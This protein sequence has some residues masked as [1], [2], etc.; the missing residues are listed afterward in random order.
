MKF[1]FFLLSLLC[2]TQI[3]SAHQING[4]IKDVNNNPIRYANVILVNKLDSSFVC[5]TISQQDGTYQLVIPKQGKYMFKVTCIGYYTQCVTYN[6]EQTLNFTL[7]VN[8]N[9]LD[10]VIIQ[11]KL[12]KYKLSP[13]GLTTNVSNSILSKLGTANDILKHIPGII[14]RQNKYEVFGKGKPAIYINGR[15]VRDNSELIQLKSSE[16]KNVEL[17]TSPSAQYDAS[18][19][20]V[21]RINTKNTKGKGWAIN[22]STSYYQS[23]NADFIE[24][25]NWEYKKK[26]LEFFGQIYSSMIKTESKSMQTI[27]LNSSS[28]WEQKNIQDYNEAAKEL[29][30]F[31]GLH[32]QLDKNH[33]VGVKY[34]LQKNPTKRQHALYTSDINKDGIYYDHLDNVI[35]GNTSF[36]PSQQVNTFYHGK[37]GKTIIDCNLEYFHQKH[38][39]KLVTLENSMS[40]T[41]RTVTSANNTK[42]QLWAMKLLFEHPLIGGTLRLGTEYTSSLHQ[43]SY[44]N[45]E[46]YLSSNHAKLVEW[47]VSPFAQFSKSGKIGQLSFGIRYERVGFI[48]YQNGVKIDE[49]SRKFSNF[50]PNMMYSTKIGQTMWQVG[51]A[52]K[53]HR[54]TY[55]QLTNNVTY[56]SRFVL[57]SGNPILKHEKIHTFSVSGMWNIIQININYHHRKDAIITW[58][59]KYKNNKNITCFSYKNIPNL[60]YMSALISVSPSLGLWSSTWSLG[61]RKQW[62]DIKTNEST[63]YLNTPIFRATSSNEF[64]IAKS[65]VGSI[66]L[67]YNSKGDINNIINDRSNLTM[68]AALIK[69]FMKNRLSI[70]LGASDIFHHERINKKM[71]FDTAFS[72]QQMQYDSREY[73][74]TL[75]FN[76]NHIKSKYKSIGAGEREKERF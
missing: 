40:R 63:C 3:I 4:T 73:Y 69:E 1:H 21:L 68:D 10:E 76:F 33:I 32:Y 46:K 19:K 75:K 38:G 50:F 39:N 35:K 5:G 29:S 61:V 59:E 54:P 25:F 41:D 66:D 28:I 13:T 51:Y 9:L 48:Y 44:V 42:N 72:S 16:I 11:A 57:Q 8:N 62:F 17:I 37:I 31:V 47:N 65:L 70:K 60:K 7:H 56:G 22:A 20:A 71:I 45:I 24:Q 58:A 15:L 64:E 30:G 26:N 55:S 27:K 74:I 34:T 14:E 43:D 12:P 6:S 18:I 49:Q 36:D 23:E 52:L 53:T 2:F 67:Y